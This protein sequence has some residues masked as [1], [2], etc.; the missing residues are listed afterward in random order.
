MFT[1]LERLNTAIWTSI[2]DCLTPLPSDSKESRFFHHIP[3]AGYL[4]LGLF[5]AP[6]AALSQ[7]F[8]GKKIPDPRQ[9]FSAVLEDSRLWKQLGDI[10][11]EITLGQND[12]QFQ[13]GVATC[14]FQ[15]SGAKNCPD[16][17]WSE[18]EKQCL[19]EENRSGSSANLFQLYR[20]PEGRKEVIDRLHK[21][22]VNSYRFSIEWSHIEPR[23]G[24]FN[25]ENLR[26]YVDLCKHLRDEGIAPFVTLHHFSEPS[27]F[28]KLGSFE[29]EENIRHFV[30][31]TQKV[32]PSLT[33]TYH[34]APL[35]E[36]FCTINEPAI[37]AA[38]RYF[39]GAYSPG[40]F[41]DFARAGNFLKGALKAHCMA[42]RTLKKLAPQVK[43]GI[44]H[45]R[46]SF[47]PGN[48]LVFPAARYLNRL[49]NESTLQ[50]F[51]TGNFA[52]KI[53]FI[54]HIRETDLAPKT[55]FVGL[56]C[57]ARPVIGLAGSTSFHEPMTEMPYREDPECLYEAILES[58]DA[59]R[60]PVIVTESGISTYDNVQRGRFNLRALYSTQK[61]Q[62]KI[63]TE[64][65]LG[66]FTWSLCDNFEWN[67]GLRPQAFGVYSQQH[68][69][70]AKSPKPGMLPFIQ[71][72]KKCRRLTLTL[73][74]SLGSSHPLKT[75]GV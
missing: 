7:A 32:F 17:Q 38:S 43:I 49:F 72:A 63:G 64:N 71:A 11:K 59:F 25:E 50:F 22:G 31:F 13:F 61:A 18:W 14:T 67:M 40:M 54:C 2:E 60:A 53:P 28:H 19:P 68:G 10:E 3:A 37:D 75:K 12:P 41:L 6:L 44:T 16:S 69:H 27:W 48:P 8:S 52:L 1:S 42:Y 39:M 47:I 33:Q 23:K 15:D 65:V 46:L 34:G 35:V 30:N 55:D 5:T 58:H 73:R 51:K 57:Y 45:Q 21:L 56:Q 9:D 26:V 20:T 74:H 29:K 4:P 24:E 36:H 66:Y 70:L 62:E